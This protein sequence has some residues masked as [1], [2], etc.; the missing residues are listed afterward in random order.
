MPVPKELEAQIRN[1]KKE[2]QTQ[3]TRSKVPHKFKPEELSQR[4]LKLKDGLALREH[5]NNMDK[6]ME[7]DKNEVKQHVEENASVVK[8]AISKKIDEKLETT[9][10]KF[11]AIATKL[12][13]LAASVSTASSSSNTASAHEVDSGHGLMPHFVTAEELQQSPHDELETTKKEYEE[14]LA[15]NLKVEEE[16]IVECDQLEAAK[17]DT[18]L[19]DA[20]KKHNDR[21]H[22]YK[23]T[24]QQQLEKT[25]RPTKRRITGKQQCLHKLKA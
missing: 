16:R 17:I 25:S 6:Q 15:A 3:H 8:E 9:T 4:R 5:Y 11:G 13:R 10:E 1:L 14:A 19:K 7:A 24:K 12:E 21:C 23:H 20:M 22:Q 18:S 2:V